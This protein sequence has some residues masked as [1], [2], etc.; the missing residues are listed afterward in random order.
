VFY[1]TK[2]DT[3]VRGPWADT[4]VVVYIPRQI[5]EIT[6][7]YP[8]QEQVIKMSKKWDTRRI[9]CIIDS[10]GNNGKSTL[11]GYMRAHNLGRKLPFSN[12][13][14]DIMRMV[15]DMPNSNCYII[16]MPRAINKEKLYQL[17]SAIEEIKGGYAYDDRYSFREKTFDCPQI[18]VF[19]NTPPDE[20]LLSRDRWKKWYIDEEH[21]LQ[22]YI[23]EPEIE[24]LE[25]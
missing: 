10:V 19:M 15:M 25:E 7:L 21:S 6:E 11:V 4:D 8:W 9:H 3:R 20:T 22:K 23:T 17:W 14:R 12:D 5:R 24:F 16:D 13:Y 18:F 2:D 1:V